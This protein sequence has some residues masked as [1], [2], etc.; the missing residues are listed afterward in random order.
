MDM[1]FSG[2]ASKDAIT[3]SIGLIHLPFGAPTI[4][5][6]PF[7]FSTRRFAE[8]EWLPTPLLN[9][10][11]TDYPSKTRSRCSLKLSSEITI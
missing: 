5:Y 2:S 10:K 9:S 1:R 6:R 11:K 4:T 3:R 7:C 8:S